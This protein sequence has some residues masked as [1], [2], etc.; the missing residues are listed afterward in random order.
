MTQPFLLLA[1]AT[2]ESSD[3]RPAS[4]RVAANFIKPPKKQLPRETAINVSASPED[5]VLLRGNGSKVLGILARLTA[6]GKIELDSTIRR[7][8]C[9]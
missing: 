9:Q 5:S 1:V 3:F 8:D 4:H 6:R 2:E 7:E